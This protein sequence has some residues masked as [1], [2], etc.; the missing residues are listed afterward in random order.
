MPEREL[1]LFCDESDREGAYYSNF[2]GG[3]LVGGSCYQAVTGRL[4][5]IKRQLNLFNEVKW[6]RVTAPYL[7]KYTVL[8]NAF[9]DELEA[10]N[11]KVRIMFRQNAE[12]A[13][14][15]TDAQREM[16]YYLLYYQFVKHAFGFPHMPIA[17][18]PVNLRIYFDRFPDTGEQVARFKGFI[19]ALEASQGFRH[20]G[21]KIRKEDIAEVDSR[22]HVLLQCLDIVLG[23]M[24]F[25]LNDKHL[26]KPAGAARRGSRTIAKEKL[27]RLINQRIRTLR[28]HFNIGITT[29]GGTTGRWA[30]PYAHWKFTPAEVHYDRMRTKRGKNKSPTEPT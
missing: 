8:V 24:C 19:A 16:S 5:H 29:G 25:R 4:N 12:E 17:G 26:A 27:Y 21:L 18:A 13:L 9:F 2:Y 14:G 20:V 6:Q 7:A 15:L 10:G 1:I 22:D 23:A 3:L 30:L 28:P 11:L